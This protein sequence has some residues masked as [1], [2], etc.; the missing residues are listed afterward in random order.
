MNYT[1]R[2]KQ[3]RTVWYTRYTNA[4]KWVWLMAAD[5]RHQP[6]SGIAPEHQDEQSDKVLIPAACQRLCSSRKTTGAKETA[7][8]A[9][10][11]N[12]QG[13]FSVYP[14]LSPHPGAIF[15]SQL[16]LPNPHTETQAFCRTDSAP[17]RLPAMTLR[18]SGYRGHQGY[19]SAY[20]HKHVEVFADALVPSCWLLQIR[21]LFM[22]MKNGI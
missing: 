14:H 12:S 18:S 5:C 16:P 2:E 15:S 17:F 11:F 21:R 8:E 9:V 13:L 4:W 10:N 3:G 19:A 7:I 20:P 1:P 22:E 6:Q